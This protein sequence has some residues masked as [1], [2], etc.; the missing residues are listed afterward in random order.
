MQIQPERRIILGRVT[1]MAALLLATMLLPPPFAAKIKREDW[2]G[3]YEATAMGTG[4]V[5][6]GAGRA[7]KGRLRHLPLDHRRGTPGDPRPDRDR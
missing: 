2:V 6:A 1:R 3:A 4:H 5:G 7:G